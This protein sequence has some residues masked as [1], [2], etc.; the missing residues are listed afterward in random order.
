MLISVRQLSGV[1]RQPYTIRAVTLNTQ[2]PRMRYLA[3]MFTSGNWRQ[4][5]R[6]LLGLAGPLIVNNL[7][8]AGIHFADAVMAGRLGA[9]T[10][11]AVAVGGSVWFFGFT[12]CL[13]ILM[14]ISPIAARHY[15][16]GNIELIGRYTRQGI[17][18][19]I[20]V[21]IAIIL[22]FYQFVGAALDVVGIDRQL[23]LAILR[24]RRS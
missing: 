20:L 22:I 18:L 13:G 12:I 15:G 14:A 5:L 7:S 24:H 1:R 2:A 23:P 19:G 17:Y 10:L 8:I 11:A 16:A 4:E 21:A 6:A 3:R 9:E